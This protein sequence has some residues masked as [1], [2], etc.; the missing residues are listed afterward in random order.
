MNRKVMIA[1]VVGAGMTISGGAFAQTAVGGN[2]VPKYTAP[3]ASKNT[4]VMNHGVGGNSAPS[5][6]SMAA[7]KNKKVTA[8]GVGGNAPPRYSATAKQ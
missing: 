7:S 1:L 3:P 2:S 4:K 8:H 6:S 5:Y